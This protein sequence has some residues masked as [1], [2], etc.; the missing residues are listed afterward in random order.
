MVFNRGEQFFQK[1]GTHFKILG[2][3]VTK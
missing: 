3:E 1:F 2:A